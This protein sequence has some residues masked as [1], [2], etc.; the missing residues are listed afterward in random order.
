MNNSKARNLIIVSMVVVFISMYYSISREAGSYDSIISRANNLM[1]KSV[2]KKLKTE[3][4]RE[5]NNYN[6]GYRRSL[7][8][9]KLSFMPDG[10]IAMKVNGA[11]KEIECHGIALKAKQLLERYKIYSKVGIG[12][13]PLRVFDT[14]YFNTIDG[15]SGVFDATPPYNQSDFEKLSERYTLDGFLPVKD[16]VSSHDDMFG[17]GT[18]KLTNNFV[19]V[20]HRKLDGHNLISNMGIRETKEILNTSRDLL[21]MITILPEK[22]T[23][24]LNYYRIEM[25]YPVN[26]YNEA[27]PAIFRQA[28]YRATLHKGKKSPLIMSVDNDVSLP[29]MKYVEKDSIRA[30]YGKLVGFLRDKKT[31][32]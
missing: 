16:T 28:T 26:E 3:V 11:Y 10:D 6:Y 15:R 20:S 22:I 13:D 21:Y 1:G 32:S 25:I 4:A 24:P 17:L 19:P 23:F 9:G 29:F 30:F 2:P 12:R 18:V 31:V 5:I 8:E 27:L 14:H 7:K